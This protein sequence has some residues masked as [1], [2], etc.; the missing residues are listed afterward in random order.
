TEE[1]VRL[2]H[3][4]CCYAP[5]AAAPEV[6]PL[7]AARLGRITFG[8]LHDLPRLNPALLDLWCAVLNSVPSARLVVFRNT[9]QGSAR[10]A[11][12]RQFAA[13]SIDAAR[14]EL[15]NTMEKP[16]SHLEVYPHIDLTLDTFPWS[17][18]TT[19]CES[20]WMGVPVVAL[21][22]PRFAGRLAA[23]VLTQVGL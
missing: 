12:Q 7:P 22:G 15:C 14:V 23:S 17:G 8:S 4:Y 2:P 5:P 3:G 9:L 10:A 6:G 18:Q 11:L 13:R 20:L 16:G 21:R 19:A 1:L